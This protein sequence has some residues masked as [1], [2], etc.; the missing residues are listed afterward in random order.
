MAFFLYMGLQYRKYGS[1]A[2]KSR[3]GD[4]AL[5]ESL[6]KRGRP[7][8]YPRI[9]LNLKTAHFNTLYALSIEIPNSLNYVGCFY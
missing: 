6:W 4:L 8:V 5:L 1:P 7:G 3:L 2:G 9:K